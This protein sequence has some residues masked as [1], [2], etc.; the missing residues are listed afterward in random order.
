MTQQKQIKLF[1]E[2]VKVAANNPTSRELG[3]SVF[4]LLKK[5]DVLEWWDKKVN[6]TKF[7]KDEQ[8]VIHAVQ[9]GWQFYRVD[10]V[11]WYY[12]NNVRDGSGPWVN[13]GLRNCTLKS[14]KI[15]ETLQKSRFPK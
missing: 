14:T 2:I 4:E 6:P 10:G 13:G 7:T 11:T 5:N 8:A 1:Q 15:W 12:A 3:E 9:S